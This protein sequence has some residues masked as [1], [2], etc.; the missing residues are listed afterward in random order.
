MPLCLHKGKCGNSAGRLSGAFVASFDGS[1]PGSFLCRSEIRNAHTSYWRDV[2]PFCLLNVPNLSNTIKETLRKS[3]ITIHCFAFRP[4]DLLLN[5]T[6]T[7]YSFASRLMLMMILC[8][9]IPFDVFRDEISCDNCERSFV[10]A[11]NWANQMQVLE[12]SVKRVQLASVR[13]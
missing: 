8:R 9:N 11:V 13:G 12:W 3:I 5:T 4:Y 10:L 6:I 1:T 2:P 7:Y